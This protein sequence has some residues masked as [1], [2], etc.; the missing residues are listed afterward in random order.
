LVTLILPD[1]CIS[2][3]HALRVQQALGAERDLQERLAAL[4]QHQQRHQQHIAGISAVRGQLDATVA[5]TDAA[6]D[7][8]RPERGAVLTGDPPEHLVERIGAAPDTPAGRAAWFHHALEIEAVIDRSGGQI[9]AWIGWSP[10]TAVRRQIAVADRLVECTSELAG[11]TEWADPPASP[12]SLGCRPT[13]EARKPGTW[14][15]FRSCRR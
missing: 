11:P 13:E 3:S 7:S 9:P 8:T 14:G 12:P 15:L 1:G 4:A 6:L 10:Q 5:R 2:R